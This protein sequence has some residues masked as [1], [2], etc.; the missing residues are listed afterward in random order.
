MIQ[1]I[2]NTTQQNETYSNTSYFHQ[3]YA[4]LEVII[5]MTLFP[6]RICIA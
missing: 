5:I 2:S 4:L 1:R 3:G 6:S